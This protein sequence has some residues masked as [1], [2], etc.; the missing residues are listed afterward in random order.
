VPGVVTSLNVTVGIRSQS[1]VAVAAGKTGVAG[2]WIGDV[3][4][5]HVIVGGVLSS[6]TIVR[7]H[8]A[9]FPQSSVA[10]HVRVT[11]YSC[12]HNPSVVAS[13]NVTATSGSQLS[14]A[15]AGGK[16]GVAGHSIGDDTAGHVI[17]GGVLSMT[18]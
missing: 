15:V 2:H 3:T 18:V 9:V 16:T 11:L 17:V 5:G 13:V 14:V 8:V 4:A 6:T 7:E 12:G 10:V 1:S